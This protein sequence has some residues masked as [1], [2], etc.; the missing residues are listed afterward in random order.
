M[1]RFLRPLLLIVLGVGLALSQTAT[2]TRNVNLRSDPSTDNPPIEKLK[3]TAQV[4]LVEPGPTDGYYHVTAPDGQD[5]W[6]WGKNIQIQAGSPSPTP[7]PT[8][9]GSPTPSPTASPTPQDL[10]SQ[11]MAARVTAVPQPLVENG[12]VTCGPTGDATNSTAIGLNTNKNRTDAPVAS[13]YVQANWDDLANLPSNRVN[14][15]VGAPVAVVGYLSHKINVENTGSGESTNCHLLGADEVDWH[16]YLTK[17]P[18]QGIKDALIVE[19]T[20]RTRPSHKWTTAMLTNY[21]NATTQV[22]ISGWLMYD[23]EHVGVIGSQRATVWEVHP[24]TRIE[25]QQN[26]QWVDLDQ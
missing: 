10:F 18:N 26:G 24:I 4:T 25:V 21:V 23:S 20:P 22:R 7:S 8:P 15:F 1:K 19:T 12:S 17:S 13:A 5:G 11:L 9:S 3:P 14:D 16:I 2:V 6:V